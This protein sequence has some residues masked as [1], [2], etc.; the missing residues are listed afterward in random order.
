M[1]RLQ[2][3]V[4]ILRKGNG[5][6]QLGSD[7]VKMIDS[8]KYSKLMGIKLISAFVIH[9]KSYENLLAKNIGGLWIT[10]ERF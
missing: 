3:H 2:L 1:L 5:P 4:G 7:R 8:T 9:W 6:S 10:L